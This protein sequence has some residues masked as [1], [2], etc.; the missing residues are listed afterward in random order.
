MVTPR[1]ATLHPGVATEGP[2]L[3]VDHPT[4]V[5]RMARLRDVGTPSSQF[6][7]LVSEISALVAYEALRDLTM[8]DVV[9]S[10]PLTSAV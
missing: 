8:T 9:V 7:Q 2:V 1:P 4:V 10:T 5:D 3:L 6:R